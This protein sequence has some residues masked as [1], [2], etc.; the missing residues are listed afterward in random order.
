MNHLCNQ[1]IYLL[2]TKGH[3]AA[4]P[5]PAS[6]HTI[7]CSAKIK[8]GFID[9]IQNHP[10]FAPL[11]AGTLFRLNVGANPTFHVNVSR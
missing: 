1:N 4:N 6:I 9:I 10:Y 2:I 7:M 8:D 3:T 11:P 5:P